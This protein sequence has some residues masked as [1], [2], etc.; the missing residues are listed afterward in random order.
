MNLEP[1]RGQILLLKKPTGLLSSDNLIISWLAQLL[2]R[3]D[4]FVT[5]L[6]AKGTLSIT[7]RVRLE[8]AVHGLGKMRA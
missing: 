1:A 2:K 8:K 4:N 3:R 7:D 6:S 5:Y